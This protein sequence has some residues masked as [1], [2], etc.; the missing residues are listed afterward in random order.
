[1]SNYQGK[2]NKSLNYKTAA[3]GFIV[4]KRKPVIVAPEKRDDNRS[5]NNLTDSQTTQRHLILGRDFED[6]LEACR[7]RNRGVTSGGIPPALLSQLKLF[8]LTGTKNE[9]A[10]ENVHTEIWGSLQ[11]ENKQLSPVRLSGVPSVK[12]SARN[13]EAMSMLK[14]GSG[15]D[16]SSH[17]TASSNFTTNLSFILG[18]S[19]M[20]IHHSSPTLKFVQI[21]QNSSARIPLV[22]TGES[23]QLRNNVSHD[24]LLEEEIESDSFKVRKERKPSIASATSL[25]TNGHGGKKLSIAALKKA[26]I[27]HDNSIFSSEAADDNLENRPGKRKHNSR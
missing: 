22:V 21:Q 8:G 13:S 15:S 10:F 24:S 17:S 6:I 9:S 3:N 26:M 1:M 11:F 19:P 20:N 27:S 4:H 16:L 14:R 7:P 2:E 5:N 25:S 18:R 12:H 23:S